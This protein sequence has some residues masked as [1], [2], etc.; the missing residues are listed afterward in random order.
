[1]RFAAF[2]LSVLIGSGSAAASEI[3]F[4]VIAPDSLH[5]V[6]PLTSGSGYNPMTLGIVNLG[7]SSF[8]LSDMTF[9]S[10]LVSTTTPVDPDIWTFWLGNHTVQPGEAYGEIA[11]GFPP[12]AWTLAWIQ[13]VFPFAT[14]LLHQNMGDWGGTFRNPFGSGV[15]FEN[16][17][18]VVAYQ[19][20]VADASATWFTSYETGSQGQHGE[21]WGTL[22][23]LESTT[24][25]EAVPEPSSLVLIATGILIA[26]G[27][28]G[29]RESRASAMSP[30]PPL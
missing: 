30:C 27:V 18:S 23:T 8:S 3:R 11:T 24:A 1:M 4:G 6:G 19:L 15:V 13:S 12:A 7:T 9:T 21:S 20:R 10:Q 17:I 2:I 29:R 22:T 5:F 26:V 16:T 14:S 28:R 25:A